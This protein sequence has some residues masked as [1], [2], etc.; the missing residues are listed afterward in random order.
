MDANKEL[1]I[2]ISERLRAEEELQR[3]KEEAEGANRAKSDFLARMSHEIRT[4][5]NG[6]LGMM[7]LL[8]ETELSPKQQTIADSVWES[9]KT[10]LELINDIL[11]FS[12][13]ESGKLQLE[14][15]DFDLPD[16]RGCHGALCRAAHRKG[17]ELVRYPKEI[18]TALAEIN[19]M[20]QVFS[21]LIGNAIKFTPRGKWASG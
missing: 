14:R 21:N 20:R 13:I 5:M 3:A 12:K 7:E 17:L 4:P 1:K 6:V 11:D 18:P 8:R 10:L 9:G 15:I 16:D 19:A 2:E